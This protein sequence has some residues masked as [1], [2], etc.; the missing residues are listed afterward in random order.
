LDESTE[1]R[2]EDPSL[3]SPAE[4]LPPNAS[5][6]EAVWASFV[7]DF[8][9]HEAAELAAWS[10]PG[11]VLLLDNPGA[12]VRVRLLDSQETVYGLEGSFDGAR[13]K[14]VELSAAIDGRAIP[15]PTCDDAEY[16]VG[17]FLESTDGAYVEKYINAL[18][19]Y[20]LAPPQE[21]DR[22]RHAFAA[23]SGKE[24][25]LVADTKHHVKFLFEKTE[26]GVHLLAI[27]AIV[28]CSA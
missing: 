19:E 24:R 20:D 26:D 11:G 28:P 22:L 27:D 21:V 9:S 2:E 3:G 1:D 12:F 10:A 15:Q 25:F 7:T 17:V 8:N 13:I 16:P 5:S 23:P 6:T 14:A 4:N 18:E